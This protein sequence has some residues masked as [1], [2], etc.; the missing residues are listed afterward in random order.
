MTLDFCN[1]G[2]H[3]A[4]ELGINQVSSGR[5][6]DGIDSTVRTECCL[7]GICIAIIDPFNDFG[8]RDNSTTVKAATRIALGNFVT[9]PYRMT[10]CVYVSGVTH[11][12]LSSA[13]DTVNRAA[14]NQL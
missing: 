2:V 4:E 14:A 5:A 7:G 3:L 6:D 1:V 8:W 12:H 9:M 10:M 13:N 11:C